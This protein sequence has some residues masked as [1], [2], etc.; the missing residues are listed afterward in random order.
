MIAYPLFVCRIS[1]VEICGA[2]G[3]AG[4][5]VKPSL[6]VHSRTKVEERRLYE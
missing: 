4:V 6:L 3:C 1:P 5:K 2:K